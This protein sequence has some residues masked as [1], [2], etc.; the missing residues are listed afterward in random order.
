[1]GKTVILGGA[2]TPFGRMS[3][4]L[5]DKKAI[6]LGA[7]AGNEAVKRAGIEPA[8]LDHIIMGQVLQGG[9]GQNPARQVGFKMGLDKEVTADT[10][11]KVC[12]SGMRA[13]TMADVFIRSGEYN[14]VLAGGMESMTNAPYALDKARGGYRLGNGVLIDLMVHDGLTDAVMSCHMGTHGSTVA[15][16]CEC[17]REAQDAYAFRSHKN[18]IAAYES[19]T[20][21]EEIVPVELKD[22]RGNVTIVDRDESPRADTSLEALAKLRPAFDPEGSV[23]AGNAPGVNDGA[24]ALVVTSEEY[25][26]EKGTQ[27]AGDDHRPRH[28]RL[29]CSLPG[30]R[31][32]DGGA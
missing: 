23:T 9:A 13:V 14:T 26:R 22:R 32:G 18:V 29:G 11:N 3:G 7:I 2:R 19:G 12:G 4:G 27:A 8:E 1:M 20:M 5:A 6:E 21:Q 15:A 16:E 31:A 24:A 17:S 30:L 25:A 10:I 28:E